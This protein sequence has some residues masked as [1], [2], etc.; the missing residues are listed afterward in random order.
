MVTSGLSLLYGWLN[1]ATSHTAV[2]T[3]LPTAGS[4]PY[5]IVYNAT[6]NTIWVAENGNTKLGSF[7]PTTNG[8]L[9]AGA[10]YER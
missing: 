1:R 6:T 4:D 8:I 2:E 9:A 10:I 5:G 3:A 7:P